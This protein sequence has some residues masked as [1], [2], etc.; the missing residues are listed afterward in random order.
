MNTGMRKIKLGCAKRAA[1]QKFDVLDGHLFRDSYSPHSS[2]HSA[3]PFGLSFGFCVPRSIREDARLAAVYHDW[4]RFLGK[5][6][7]RRV[8]IV[9]TQDAD[10]NLRQIV[11][12]FPM[13][14][15][16]NNARGWLG[17]RT[18]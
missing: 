4:A 14:A 2:F 7:W 16:N 3:N 1:H 6:L 13:E 9:A 8:W 12:H 17:I 18:A 15:F 11:V 5:S 10:R